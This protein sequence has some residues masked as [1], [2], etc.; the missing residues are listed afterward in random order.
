MIIFI[1]ALVVS[2]QSSSSIFDLGSFALSIACQMFVPL[3]AI[4]YIPWFTKNG[5]SPKIIGEADDVGLFEL[6]T[7]TGIAF[8]IVPE[9][10]K[11]RICQNKDVI[12]LGEL[13]ELQTSVWGIVKN[14]YRGPGYQ[15]LKQQQK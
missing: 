12:V 5:I 11:N 1:A 4:C 15:L 2:I 8:T 6:V 13:E 10:A 3:M 14:N 9:V 7:T